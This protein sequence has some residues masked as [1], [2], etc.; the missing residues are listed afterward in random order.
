MI[1]I[2]IDGK[3]DNRS[4]ATHDIYISDNAINSTLKEEEAFDNAE[5][6][7]GVDAMESMILAHHLA[8]VDITDARYIEGIE[9]AYE[10]I[11]NNL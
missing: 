8:G 1:R 4:P 3:T 10:A 2:W 5:F 6:N 11:G 9:T 7:A